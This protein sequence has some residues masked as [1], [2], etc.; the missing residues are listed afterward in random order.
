MAARNHIELV[1]KTLNV[2]EALADGEAGSTLATL[3]SRTG[4]VKSSTFRILYTLKE[5]GYVDQNGPNGPYRLTLK[6]LALARRAAI[7]PTLINVARPH[8]VRLRDR[9]QESVWLA[10]WRR[11]E[12]VLA[13]V[14]EA[15]HKLRLSLD[16]GDACPLHASA[17]GK[18]VAAHLSPE[19]LK[20]VLG[21]APLPRYTARTL[22][23]RF[24]LGQ[25]LERVRRQGFAMNEEETIEGALLAGAP[26]FDAQRRVCAAVSVSCPTAR[27]PQG[28]RQAM[29]RGVI[30]AAAAI[31]ADLAALGFAAR[32]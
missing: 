32:L 27:C 14:A 8:L 11:R 21:D 15:A 9:L 20:G 28:K 6:A 25:E 3:A 7:R 22:T 2:L 12:V 30:A 5:L 16:L 23:S 24:R 17:L 10:E 1:E 18:A 26:V 29:V 31:S 4:L 13:D 19:Q